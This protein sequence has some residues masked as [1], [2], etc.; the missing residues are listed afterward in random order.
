MQLIKLELSAGVKNN[1]NY[2]IIMQAHC[3]SLNFSVLIVQQ[4]EKCPTIES[5]NKNK[6]LVRESVKA[7]LELHL[8]TIS[9]WFSSQISSQTF[10]LYF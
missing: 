5:E 9:C 8:V 3:K 2:I 10:R 1:N 4:N 6:V 7:D